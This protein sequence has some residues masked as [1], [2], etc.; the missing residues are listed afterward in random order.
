MKTSSAFFFLLAAARH[1]GL[2]SADCGT[3]TDT[4]TKDASVVEASAALSAAVQSAFEI[5]GNAATEE[6]PT[7]TLDV[8]ADVQPQYGDY[9][10]AC[11]SAGGT[12]KSLDTIT[13][14]C[15]DFT[16][17]EENY[18]ACVAEVCT[19]EEVQAFANDSVLPVVA[20]VFTAMG[21]QCTVTSGD[22]TIES[23]TGGD[24]DAEPGTPGTTT[25]TNGDVNKDDVES[26]CGTQT[27]TISKDDDVIKTGN[28]LS[29]AV[30]ASFT[31]MGNTATE[32]NPTLELDVKTVDPEYQN[33][34][35]A[36]TAAGGT[37]KTLDTIT[38]KCNTFTV[39]ED[40]YPACVAGVCTDEEVQNFADDMVLPVIE[41]VFNAL[42]GMNCTVMS[43][44]GDDHDM[45]DVKSGGSALLANYLLAV[46]SFVVALTL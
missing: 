12:I 5:Q 38:I 14:A 13:I 31:N 1:S 41:E 11:T 34:V 10:A 17:I 45:A 29:A 2:A 18:P 28:Q 37:I 8:P 3:E 21:M 26:E 43:D 23:N 9:E 22:T 7:L 16:V 44:H 6:N 24:S 30:S 32:E 15:A 42:P 25:D 40:S 39:I 36:C 20:D 19:D 33:Y 46:G 27:D 4:I 35:D